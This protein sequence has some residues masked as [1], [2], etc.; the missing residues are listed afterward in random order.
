[1]AASPT[2]LSAVETSNELLNL[3]LWHVAFISFIYKWT[4]EKGLDILPLFSCFSCITPPLSEPVHSSFVWNRNFLSKF[5]SRVGAASTHTFTAALRGRNNTATWLSDDKN[6]ITSEGMKEGFLLSL[7]CFFFFFYSSFFPFCLTSF[8]GNIGGIKAGKKANV[9]Q[10]ERQFV[11]VSI[12]LDLR[13]TD[14][15]L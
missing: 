3:K 6:Q 2:P 4:P 13:Q 5:P 1:M 15:F 14:T 10:G 8:S 12:Q 7:F 11:N 9:L